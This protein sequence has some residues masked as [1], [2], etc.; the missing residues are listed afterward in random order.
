MDPPLAVSPPERLGVRLPGRS[1][2]G[3]LVQ[4]TSEFC[5]TLFGFDSTQGLVRREFQL[6]RLAK[7]L[8][9]RRTHLLASGESGNK[10]VS[11]GID[12]GG[13]ISA[14]E[15]APYGYEKRREIQFAAFRRWR[16]EAR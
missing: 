14:N 5:S 11:K 16:P 15:D 2:S 12:I 1:V 10:G 13:L 6:G 9:N 3:K 4:R 8:G 7:P